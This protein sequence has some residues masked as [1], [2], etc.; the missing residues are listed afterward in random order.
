M[1]QK[2]MIRVSKSFYTVAEGRAAG[3]DISKRIQSAQG[4]GGAKIHPQ[5]VIRW[6]QRGLVKIDGKAVRL[7]PFGARLVTGSANWRGR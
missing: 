3:S 7:T 6:Q 1:K 4:R 2:K 5:T